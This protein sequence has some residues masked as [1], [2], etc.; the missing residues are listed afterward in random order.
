MGSGSVRIIRCHGE[1]IIAT[2]GLSHPRSL[3]VDMTVFCGSYLVAEEYGLQEYGNRGAAPR[4]DGPESL[5]A[6]THVIIWNLKKRTRSPSPAK[7]WTDHWQNHGL[8]D[9]SRRRARS[10]TPVSCAELIFSSNDSGRVGT[11]TASWCVNLDR[12]NGLVL[13]VRSVANG[14]RTVFRRVPTERFDVDLT[15][16]SGGAASP[17]SASA[18]A[19]RSFRQRGGLAATTPEPFYYEAMVSIV[20]SDRV[21]VRAPRTAAA[22][23]V[24]GSRSISTAVAQLGMLTGA[25]LLTS[26]P[27]VLSSS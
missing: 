1:S 12:T 3:I 17:L 5:R 2:R 24:E 23:P 13:S 8:A 19:A 16:I 22:M 21:T 7:G 14:H 4:R 20:V 9:Q 10:G 11:A 6:Q 27:L 26:C 15:V 25:I 18:P